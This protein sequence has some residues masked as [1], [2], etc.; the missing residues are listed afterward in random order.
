M[1]KRLSDHVLVPRH[2][3]VSREEE[4]QVLTKL[5]VE[6]EKLPVI[7]ESDP[8]AM[9]VKAKKGDLVRIVRKSPTAGETIYYR[10]VVG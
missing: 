1:I 10:R 6:K 7:L 3:V 9:E 2:E 8:S 4:A 5:G